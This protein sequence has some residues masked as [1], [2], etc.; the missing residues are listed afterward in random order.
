[1]YT[2][3]AEYHGRWGGRYVVNI[4]AETFEDAIKKI[5]ALARTRGDG[6]RIKFQSLVCITELDA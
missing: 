5:K 6:R 4:A 1:M 3:K 2:W